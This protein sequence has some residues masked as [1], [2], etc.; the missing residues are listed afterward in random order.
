MSDQPTSFTRRRSMGAAFVALLAPTELLVGCSGD[1]SDPAP[2]DTVLRNGYVYTVDEHDAVQQA[3][4]VRD[5]L[6]VHVG[7][8]SSAAAYIG[9]NTQV[10]DLAGRMLMPGFVDAHMHPLAGGRALLQANL[11]YAPLTRAQ[12]QTLIQGFLDS[13]A[14][15]EPDTWLEVVNW[16]RQSTQSLD[17][18]PTK[19]TLDALHTSR[20]ILVRSSDFHTVLTNSR[21]LALAGVT[22][23]TP[24]PTGGSFD[25]DADGNPTGICEDAAGWAV[26]AVIPPDTEAD[27]L[28]QARAALAQMRR[29][30]ITTFMDASA[31]DAQGS[32]FT[33]LQKSGELTARA[34][35]AIQIAAEDAAA[36]PAAA[37]AA[38]ATLANTYDQGEPQV[39]PGI[40]FRH[41]K[42]FGDGVVNAPADTGGLLTP[43]FTNAGTD[44]AP[45]WVPGTNTGADYFP[46]SVLNPLMAAIASSGFDPHVHA[47][48]ERTVRQVLDAVAYA[49]TQVSSTTFRP[50]IAH[51]ETVAVADYPRYA[52]LDVMA[53]FAFQWAQQ[54]G[55]SVGDTQYHLGEDRFQRME[56]FGSV[57]N[58]GARVGFGSD[59]PIDPMDEFL[60]LKC[61]VT[62]SGDPQ[63][64]NSAAYTNPNYTGPI[65]SDP[66]LSRADTLRAITLNSAWQLR[67]EQNIGSIEVGKYADLIVLEN[68][69]MQASDEALGRNS[70]LLTMVGGTV[71]MGTGDY[72]T[73]GTTLN[74]KISAAQAS[75]ARQIEQAL[76]WGAY[77][78]YACQCGMRHNILPRQA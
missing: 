71:V 53:S 43:Y 56:P 8:N 54:A 17:T 4:A 35:F 70:V 2:A 37:V 68:N 45:N 64:P 41:L 57:R 66:A 39:T 26:S 18:D 47:T 48:G 23:D 22:R 58:A 9:P 15:Q 19:E 50:V 36:D 40:R 32:A 63:N 77:N 12:M 16:D 5:G 1:S 25:R 7:S 61:A 6:I 72:A 65:N 20:P 27:Q 52:Q 76:N 73:L 78:P 24:D 74:A 59:W 33:A 3:V 69:F 62:R 67:M 30:G 44:A 55:Y 34:F 10:I 38:A 21:G 14:D 31:G 29:S 75:R 51:N 49:R 28:N 46:P 13:T 11:N 60:A 42:L